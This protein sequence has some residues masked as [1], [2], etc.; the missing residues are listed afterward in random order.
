MNMMSSSTPRRVS[1]YKNQKKKNTEVKASEVRVQMRKW[2]W[3]LLQAV[4]M[5]E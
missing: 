4:Q 5:K 3:L 1:N 2:D